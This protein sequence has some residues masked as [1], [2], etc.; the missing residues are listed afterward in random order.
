MCRSAGG[1]SQ[2]TFYHVTSRIYFCSQ[3]FLRNTYWNGDR[4]YKYDCVEYATGIMFE[5]VAENEITIQTFQIEE[6]LHEGVFAYNIY[7][8][9]GG[10]DGFQL[11]QDAWTKLG[12]SVIDMSDRPSQGW[13]TDPAYYNVLFPSQDMTPVTIYPG[14]TRS[15]YIAKAIGQTTPFRVSPTSSDESNGD[16]TVKS[17][18]RMY[19]Y[20]NNFYDSGG[21]C[22]YGLQTAKQFANFRMSNQITATFFAEKSFTPVKLQLLR[23]VGGWCLHLI[24]RSLLTDPLA[25]LISSSQR[26]AFGSTFRS[27]L[28]LAKLN[29]KLSPIW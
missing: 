22:G 29:S 27:T 28:Y 8:K 9:T 4:R 12:E 11:N 21:R 5:I 17:G 26:I 23:T 25:N 24:K 18:F 15:F 16:L 13:T 6:F 2:I 1:S 3:P 14:E 7:T 10:W 20:I 19:P